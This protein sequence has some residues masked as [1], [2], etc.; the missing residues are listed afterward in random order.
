MTC[1]RCGV[2]LRKYPYGEGYGY[3]GDGIFCTLRCGYG[4]AVAQ[5]RKADR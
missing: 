5:V 4:W 1:K 2:K 3:V